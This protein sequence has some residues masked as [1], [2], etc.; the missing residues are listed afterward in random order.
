MINLGLEL[1]VEVGVFSATDTLGWTHTCGLAIHNVWVNRNTEKRRTRTKLT[2]FRSSRLITE[3]HEQYLHIR[4]AS[5]SESGAF[6]FF[7][8]SSAVLMPESINSA[9]RTSLATSPARFSSTISSL[10]C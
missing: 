1:N 2:S 5:L 6:P 4:G 10:T 7:R 9:G 3:L 8:A